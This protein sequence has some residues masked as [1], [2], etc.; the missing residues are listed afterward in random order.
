[1]AAAAEA[2]VMLPASALPVA[3]DLRETL[4]RHALDV[5]WQPFGPAVDELNAYVV[6]RGGANADAFVSISTQPLGEAER[7]DL[8]R[9]ATAQIASAAEPIEN[10]DTLVRISATA[11]DELDWKRVFEKL[12]GAIASTP[13]AVTYLVNEDEYLGAGEVARRMEGAG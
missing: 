3:V 9:R 11:G 7:D 12:V 13:Q 10:A 8:L 2:L 6:P 5:E 1:M 4:A